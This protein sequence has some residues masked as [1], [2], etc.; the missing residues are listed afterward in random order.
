MKT[1][2]RMEKFYG[3]RIYFSANNVKSMITLHFQVEILAPFQLALPLV[4]RRQITL[5]QGRYPIHQK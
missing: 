5:H 4:A 2:T 1:L 3:A